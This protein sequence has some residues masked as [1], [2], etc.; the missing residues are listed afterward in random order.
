MGLDASSSR[1]VIWH[2]Q[3]TRYGG[4]LP[5]SLTR[6]VTPEPPLS[7]ETDE[8]G[9]EV[10]HDGLDFDHQQRASPWVNGEDVD[11]ASF[12]S[13]IERGLRRHLPTVRP[14]HRHELFDEARVPCIE[15]PIK[16]LAVPQQSEIHP[17]AQHRG[18]AH[19]RVNRHPVGI[20][21]LDPPDDRA[22]NAA[23]GPQLFLGQPSPES[24]G[25]DT[26]PEP[27]DVHATKHGLHRCTRGLQVTDRG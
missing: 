5:T 17:R 25:P 24:Q 3:Q 11:R 21:P 1:S 4:H 6:H 12:A 9:L 27:D 26:E 10:G 13:D 23:T 14:Q 8:H 7:V 15:Q 22:R 18:N 20:P 16:A 2:D 19:E